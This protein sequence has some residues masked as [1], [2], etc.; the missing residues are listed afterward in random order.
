MKG[1]NIPNSYFVPFYGVVTIGLSSVPLL[2]YSELFYSYS[3]Y[4][5]ALCLKYPRTRIVNN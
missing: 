2:I 5:S 3:L 4:N 1:C